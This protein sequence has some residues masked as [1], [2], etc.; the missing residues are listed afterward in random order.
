MAHD[1]IPE[2]DVDTRSITEVQPLDLYGY[3]QHHFFAGIG[4]WPCALRMGGWRDDRPCCTGSCPCPPFSSAGKKKTCPECGGKRPIPCPWKTGHFICIEC[5]VSWHAD[6]RHLFPEFYRLIRDFGFPVIIGEQVAGADGLIWLAGVRASLERIAYSVGAVDIAAASVGAPHIRQRLKWV[7]VANSERR[8]WSGDKQR[9][10][11]PG[12][13]GESARRM[14]SGL[15]VDDAGSVGRRSGGDDHARDERLESSPAS[16]PR[17]V[18]DSAGDDERGASD[19]AHREGEPAGGSSRPGGLADSDRD[20]GAEQ[21]DQSGG[22]PAQEQG[23]ASK[24][25]RPRRVAITP[26]EGLPERGDQSGTP[27]QPP[28]VGS[29]LAGG[30]GEPEHVRCDPVEAGDGRG[31]EGQGSEDG[32]IADRSSQ[33]GGTGVPGPCGMGEPKTKGRKK[34]QH[35]GGSGE[36]AGGR[37]WLLRARRPSPACGVV[38]ATDR[39]A[40][41]DHATEPGGVRPFYR[42]PWPSGAWDNFDVLPCRDGKAR[43]V[44]SG[45]FPL[46]HGVPFRV[47]KLRGYGDA[48]VLQAAATFIESLEAAEPLDWLYNFCVPDQTG[49]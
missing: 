17:R 6:H 27:E 1:L 24:R 28:L 49:Q 21:L 36:E 9:F 8:T 19:R 30:V 46:A 20:G 10:G 25:R 37:P 40:G 14:P 32:A 38:D 18:G 43:R 48:I 29:G 4:G 12:G 41:H 15:W 39:G 3:R 2:G 13:W 7:A 5:G 23:N 44:E 26:S 42:L 11:F 34:R 47:V 35:R 16:G 22:R 31:Q 33:P 45:T